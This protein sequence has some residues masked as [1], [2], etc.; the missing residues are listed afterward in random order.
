M[1]AER[2]A[3]LL[4]CYHKSNVAEPEIFAAGAAAILSK[5][6]ADIAATVTDPRTGLAGRLKFVPTLAEIREACEREQARIA[7][8]Q[9]R[10]TV[11]K[12]S[13]D[14]ELEMQEVRARA[15]AESDR[16][17]EVVRQWR[18]SVATAPSEGGLSKADL[19]DARKIDEPKWK[20][21]VS[22]HWARRASE[23]AERYRNNPCVLSDTARATM[24]L[25]PLRV[26]AAE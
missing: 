19:C 6:P 16:R 9:R 24:G 13:W 23:N 12:E 26:E 8:E 22:A 1:G 4:G 7:V 5:F 10:E 11:L 15:R 25:P 21:A 17:K 2:A 20:A 14:A 18:E 3:L